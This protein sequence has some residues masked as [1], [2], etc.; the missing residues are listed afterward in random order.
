MRCRQGHNG[1]RVASAAD[2]RR[3]VA[4]CTPHRAVKAL[5]LHNIGCG[6]ALQDELGHSVA[7]LHCRVGLRQAR[8]L[9]QAH[10]G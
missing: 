5:H 6:N 8:S 10:Y 9:E 3:S 1:K 4:T 7:A 2:A